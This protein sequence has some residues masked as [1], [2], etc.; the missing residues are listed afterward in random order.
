MPRK[1]TKKKTATVFRYWSK[2]EVRILKRY[3]S[4]I[5]A[6]GMTEKLDR[7]ARGITTKAHTLGLYFIEASRAWTP[8]QV[9]R[10]RK[11]YPTM[12]S[13]MA[14]DKLGRTLHAVDLKASKLGLRKSK[15]YMKN[16]A[17]RMSLAYQR[18]LANL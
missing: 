13:R 3:Y 17:R 10:L 4:K 2:E 16:V 8:S 9:K 5:G 15:K 1:K 18:A 14:A 6:V 11:Y 12:S 7:S